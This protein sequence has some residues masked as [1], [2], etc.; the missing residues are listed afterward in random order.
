MP[1]FLALRYMALSGIRVLGTRCQGRLEYCQFT[2]VCSWGF[3]PYFSF[4]FKGSVKWYSILAGNFER[5]FA[6]S[7]W[8][9]IVRA[10]LRHPKFSADISCFLVYIGRR[11]QSHDKYL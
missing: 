8:R 1:I 6:T 9:E 7:F 5:A 11:R 3:V 4:P 2:W 10:H